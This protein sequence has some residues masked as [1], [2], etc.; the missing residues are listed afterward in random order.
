M[1]N[2]SSTFKD[3][4]KIKAK[5]VISA[6]DRPKYNQVLSVMQDICSCYDLAVRHWNELSS[7]QRIMLESRWTDCMLRLLG[8]GNKSVMHSIHYRLREQTPEEEEEA[9]E[10]EVSN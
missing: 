10:K 7:T 6:R 1:H 5:A 9:E 8:I 3:F 2:G 4:S